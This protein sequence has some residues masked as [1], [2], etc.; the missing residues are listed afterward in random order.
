MTSSL[1]SVIGASCWAL[2][3]AGWLLE[4][5]TRFSAAVIFSALLSYII[6]DRSKQEKDVCLSY[7]FGEFE[8]FHDVENQRAGDQRQ[9]FSS[10]RN[11][12]RVLQTSS[13]SVG[14]L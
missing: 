2:K 11:K 7:R 13:N 5:G 10:L 1:R 9:A 4:Y 14:I 8:Y 3:I 12:N 6:L